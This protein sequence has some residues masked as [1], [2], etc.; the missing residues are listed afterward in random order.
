MCTLLCSLAVVHAIL[1][2]DREIALRRTFW[3]VA[4]IESVGDPRAVNHREDAVGIVGIRPI[5]VR[6][7][8]RIFGREKYAFADRVDVQKSYEMFRL[9]SRY[10]APRGTPEIWA[11]NW[12]GGPD[13]A[14][15]A[16][17]LAYWLKVQRALARI[18]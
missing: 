9:Y 1:T 18:H 7:V 11:R 17:T 3:A 14:R 16:C 5:M 15:Q 13:G 4:L 2:A 6:D 8:N 10:Y 12:N